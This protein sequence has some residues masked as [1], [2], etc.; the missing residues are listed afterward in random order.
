MICMKPC[1][2]ASRKCGWPITQ[3]R[4]FDTIIQLLETRDAER[5]NIS[6]PIA[7]RK[8]VLHHHHQCQWIN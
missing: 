4:E 1:Q 8:E 2:I 6:N 3:L 7:A 5:H